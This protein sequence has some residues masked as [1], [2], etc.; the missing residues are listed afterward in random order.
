MSSTG[1][2]STEHLLR[3]GCLCGLE[4][5]A[6]APTEGTVV[7]QTPPGE[8]VSGFGAA[9]NSKRSAFLEHVYGLVTEP[10]AGA[11]AKP[12]AFGI[13]YP[14]VVSHRDRWGHRLRSGRLFDRQEQ[15][16][17][18]TCCPEVL[19]AESA[20]SHGLVGGS[21]HVPLYPSALEVL[22]DHS[23]L[24]SELAYR[25]TEKV[26]ATLIQV[27]SEE[28]KTD[29]VPCFR[30]VAAQPVSYQRAGHWISTRR[31]VAQ[32]LPQRA[33]SYLRR[34]SRIRRAL[35]SCALEILNQMAVLFDGLRNGE[36]VRWTT[37]VCVEERQE[38]LREVMA[39]LREVL[40]RG[41]L[42]LTPT[43]RQE[44]ERQNETRD[45]GR[46][47]LFAH[48]DFLSPGVHTSIIAYCGDRRQAGVCALRRG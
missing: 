38:G 34:I 22:G 43:V 36:A 14:H 12:R 47:Q 3:V 5:F 11:E 44:E 37:S 2:R 10:G 27:R 33:Q 1:P 41:L 46:N 4:P 16:G 28:A 32:K 20:E 24:K 13:H 45:N 25:E 35:H 9:D 30:E 42:P 23:L 26:G 15:C 8:A 48:G 7:V 29:V 6:G 31:A 19:L 18:Q 21:V 40:S 39:C 17:I